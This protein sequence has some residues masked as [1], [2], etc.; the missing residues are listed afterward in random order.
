MLG[1]STADIAKAVGLHP[2]T[3]ER[4]RLRHNIPIRFLSLRELCDLLQWPRP[5]IKRIFAPA[6]TPRGYRRWIIERLLGRGAWLLEEPPFWK[7]RDLRFH[8]IATR[9][10]DTILRAVTIDRAA[11]IT[12]VDPALI[13]LH[14]R[15]GLLDAIPYAR[16]WLIPIAS[17]HRIRN[18][19]R[20]ARPTLD[21]DEA[22]LVFSLDAPAL[23]RLAA[24]RGVHPSRLRRQARAVLSRS[25]R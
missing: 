25:W 6:K 12:G 23:A 5:A 13:R 1:Y 24:Q 20:W 7:I 21:R 14:A 2:R 17:L 4:Y 22:M 3:V 9:A 11:V 15:L 10:V 19:A 18:L 8:A 16:G